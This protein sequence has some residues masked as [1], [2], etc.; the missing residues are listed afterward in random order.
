M[1]THASE[2]K[3]EGRKYFETLPLSMPMMRRYEAVVD[4]LRGL[5]VEAKDLP[6]MRVAAWAS[7]DKWPRWSDQVSGPTP[8]P[9]APPPRDPVDYRDMEPVRSALMRSLPD[10]ADYVVRL[11]TAG[12]EMLVLA[13]SLVAA[14][15]GWMGSMRPSQ[16]STDQGL[17]AMRML[18]EFLRA[19]VDLDKIAQGLKLERLRVVKA[20]GDEDAHAM[21]PPIVEAIESLRAQRRKVAGE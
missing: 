3:V 7:R 5:F 6:P 20:T 1:L 2:M 11:E 19:A 12:R 4:H 10:D 16:W 14:I 17:K 13:E 21:P 8:K 15:P 18:P 9:P